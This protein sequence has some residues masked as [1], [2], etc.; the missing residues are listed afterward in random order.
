[1]GD[2]ANATSVS[3][4]D[5]VIHRVISLNIADVSDAEVAADWQLLANIRETE[6]RDEF[7]GLVFA[8]RRL[9]ARLTNEMTTKTAKKPP[10]INLTPEFV[11][12]LRY[13]PGPTRFWLRKFKIK[14]VSSKFD[15]RLAQCAADVR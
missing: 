12:M 9:H 7:E 10:V 8:V 4:P 13:G 2:D 1:M 6:T 3:S 14:T 11:A 15:A 5:S